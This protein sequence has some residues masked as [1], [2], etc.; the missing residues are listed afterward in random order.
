MEEQYQMTDEEV[1]EVAIYDEEQGSKCPEC[2][3]NMVVTTW[4]NPSTYQ[5]ETEATCPECGGTE[6]TL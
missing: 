4:R 2:G 5:T 1:Q 6:T 3:T